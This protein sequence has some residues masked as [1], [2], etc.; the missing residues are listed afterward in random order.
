LLLVKS[1]AFLLSGNELPIL[2][3]VSGTGSGELAY[4]SEEEDLSGSISGSQSV[5]SG[6]A[7]AAPAKAPMEASRT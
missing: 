6:N 5:G 2:S 7:R 3:Y 1:L 4:V